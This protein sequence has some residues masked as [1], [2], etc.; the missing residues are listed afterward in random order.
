[1]KNKSNKS[2]STLVNNGI[3]SFNNIWKPIEDR[4]KELDKE[5][6]FDTFD[7]VRDSFFT[8]STNFA[9][10]L[11]EIFKDVKDT[12]KAF[13]YKV[14]VDKDKENI[15]YEFEDGDFGK[16]LRVIIKSKD[17]S[18]KT[19][20]YVSIPKDCDA[21]KCLLSIMKTKWKK[22]LQFQNI[23]IIIHTRIR[24]SKITRKT[25]TT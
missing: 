8:N 14:N 23:I 10:D 13:T 16:S 17:G 19:V 21:K 1:M 24:N 15:S 22:Y 6:F 7:K 18:S 25:I 20:N 11:K 2:L 3:E 5:M 12:K 9:N 4:F